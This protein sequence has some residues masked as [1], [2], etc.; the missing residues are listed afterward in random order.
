MLTFG[1]HTQVLQTI[2]EKLNRI[3][4]FRYKDGRQTPEEEEIGTEVEFENGDYLFP[5][6]RQAL[7]VP[8]VRTPIM[9][10]LI[11]AGGG[12]RSQFKAP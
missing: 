10:G 3:F 11:A 2:C 7:C 1:E 12:T 6:M 4:C 8:E 9:R 5:M